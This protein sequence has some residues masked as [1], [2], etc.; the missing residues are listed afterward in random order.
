MTYT[1]SVTTVGYRGGVKRSERTTSYPETLI[2]TRRRTV[3]TVVG[4]DFI[5]V[6]PPLRGTRE[7]T[8]T[9]TFVY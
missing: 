6:D 5:T 8:R 1:R 9:P 7:R 3:A 4:I 2:D